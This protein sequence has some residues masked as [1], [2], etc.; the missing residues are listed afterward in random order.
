MTEVHR[1]FFSY[2][3]HLE[4]M[5]I[6]VIEQSGSPV[7]KHLSDE[8]RHAAVFRDLVGGCEKIVPRSEAMDALRQYLLSLNEDECCVAL[9]IVGERWLAS[10]LEEVMCWP[11][12]RPYWDELAIVVRDE[13]RHA[14]IPPPQC[15]GTHE[16]LTCLARLMTDIAMDPYFAIP[17]YALGGYYGYGRVG[18]TCVKAHR[19][20]C[21]VLDVEP[22]DDLRDL[23][24]AA[25]A[26]LFT[27]SFAPR[28]IVS[29][30]RW[31]KQRLRLF[32][33][34]APIV[35]NIKVRCAAR[36]D[37]LIE[38]LFVKAISEV[39]ANDSIFR[40]VVRGRQVYEVATNRVA[41]RRYRGA[42]LVTIGIDNARHQSTKYVARAIGRKAKATRIAPVVEPVPEE[43]MHELPPARASVVFSRIPMPDTAWGALAVPI[44]PEGIPIQCY[45]GGREG[46]YINFSVSYD[47][48]VGDGMTMGRFAGAVREAVEAQTR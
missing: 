14:D 45:A 31:E 33:R 28:P 37:W 25:R 4:E 11:T 40:R 47:H 24:K 16:V 20:A 32:D 36:S 2:L 19:R 42:N 44:E 17:M 8:L 43:L 21:E 23:D 41:V 48:R 15:D 3:Y 12:F 13:M 6:A 35:G 38:A 26:S 9:N 39:V 46:T 34:A 22:M 10:V 27:M 5:A 30:S 1:H 29:L 7:R 18:R